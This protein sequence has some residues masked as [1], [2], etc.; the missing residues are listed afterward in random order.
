MARSSA[1]RTY[2]PRETSVRGLNPS[3]VTTIAVVVMLCGFAVADKEGPRPDAATVAAEESRSEPAVAAVLLAPSEQR[4]L[5]LSDEDALYRATLW[6]ARCIYSET[7]RRREQE[8]V[9]WVVRNRVETRYRGESTYANVVTDPFQFSAFNRRSLTR[10]FLLSVDSTYAS[11][12]WSQAMRVARDVIMADADL[13]P[14]P[15]TTR[16]FYSER[17]LGD[18]DIPVWALEVKPVR[19]HAFSLDEKRF[20]FFDRVS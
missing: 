14:F 12:E 4:A 10:E 2:C 3:V 13:R 18:A 7:G 17:S 15:I 1:G 11:S 5:L 19:V 9:A 16:H 8:L 20:R 6:L